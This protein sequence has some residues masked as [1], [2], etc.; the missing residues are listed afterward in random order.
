M[1]ALTIYQ[2]WASLVIVGAKPYE[3]RKWS[4]RERGGAYAELIGQR[5]G[6][7]ASTR[8]IS[9]REVA[10]IK[11]KLRA[12]GDLAAETCLHADKAEPVLREASKMTHNI[13]LPFGALIG[14]AI[15]GEPRNAMDIAAEF[16]LSWANDS[17]RR[18]HANYGWPMLEIERW[19]EPVACRGFQGFWNMPTPESVG[20]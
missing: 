5:I 8:P 3:F 9:A 2:P 11:R 7:H 15:L 10:E 6:I 19:D 20:L 17:D 14:T 18:D 13:S 1:K 16:G 4:P 12:G